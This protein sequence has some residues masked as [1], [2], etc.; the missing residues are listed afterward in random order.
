MF[1][2][3]RWWS[4]HG[5]Q[6]I[7]VGL[8]LV[9]AGIIRQTQAVPL[10]ELYYWLQR[11]LET[12]QTRRETELT[13]ARIRELQ[14]RVKELEKQNQQLQEQLG[15]AENQSENLK[16]APIIGRSPDHW[17]Q[18]ITIGIGSNAGVEEG[19][20]VTGLG[21]LVGRVERVTPNSSLVALV[22]NPESRVGVII[23]RSRNMGFIS[24]QGD[25]EVVMQFFQKLPDVEKGDAVITS[26]ASRLFPSGI[27][28]GEITAIDL[29]KSP[30]P[31]ATVRLNVPLEDIEWVFVRS[32]N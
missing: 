22:S 26:P 3:R 6:M 17:W 7:M 21:G 32:K 20:T 29:D 19:D 16:T 2:V 18:Q 14:Q 13:N 8:L 12:V 25:R 15:Y 28:V 11:P 31:E 27:A 30:A 24:G 1:S 5:S 4:Q 23:S 9:V 10:Y